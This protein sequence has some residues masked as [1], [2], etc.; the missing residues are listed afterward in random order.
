MKQSR[1]PALLVLVIVAIVVIGWGGASLRPAKGDQP[2][3]VALVETPVT[4]PPTP[5]PTLAVQTPVPTATTAPTPEPTMPPT[6][7]PTIPPTPEETPRPVAPPNPYDQSFI[8]ERGE[9]GRREIAITFDAGEGTGAVGEMLDFLKENNVKVSFGITG[10]WAR[11]N[12][13]L[14]QRM[15]DEGHM[16]FSHSDTHLSWTGVSTGLDPIP[17]DV[18]ISELDGAEQ[19]VLDITGYE[20]KPF[21]R[22]PYGDYD[23]DGLKLLKQQG[24][25]Y[26]VWWTCDSF[27]W[28]GATAEEVM[29]RCGPDS[30]LGGPG[31]IILM[32][33]T[34]EEDYRALKM[35][36][37][38]YRADGYDFVTIEQL[39]QP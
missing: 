11:E 2:T 21:F 13:E 12:P 8:I 39:I 28:Q 23:L 31:G 15:V 24:Y 1:Q 19:A 27:G 34:Q 16:L 26:T 33:V 36:V 18:R 29:E 37:D 35:L 30:D 7:S 10:N 9:S 20:M 14:L 6:P 38:A 3:A 22:P 5:T 17:D 4:I 32:H 25:E